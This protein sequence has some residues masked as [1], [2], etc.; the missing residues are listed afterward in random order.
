MKTRFSAE[1]ET[2]TSTLCADYHMY[3]RKISN[4][5]SF[6]KELICIALK[7]YSSKTNLT[8]LGIELSNE[9]FQV[10][11]ALSQDDMM[12]LFPGSLNS[13]KLPTSCHIKDDKDAVFKPKDLKMK[14][15]NDMT[16]SN[17]DATFVVCCLSKLDQLPITVNLKF[18]TSR[19]KQWKSTNSYK[20]SSKH[21]PLA[22][23]DTHLTAWHRDSMFT[24]KV[25][26]ISP[27]SM[28]VWVF[29]KVSGEMNIPDTWSL[30]EQMNHILIHQ[31]NLD[32]F[33]QKPGFLVKHRGSHAHFVLTYIKKDS[34]YGL[35]SVLVGWE[36][37]TPNTILACMKEDGPLVQV[38]GGYLKRVPVQEY[39][40]TVTSGQTLTMKAIA[41]TQIEITKFS[42]GRKLNSE[43]RARKKKSKAVRFKN[44][45]SFK[46]LTSQTIPLSC[47]TS[48]IS[49]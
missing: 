32:F 42:I 10:L 4:G 28:K 24:D 12:N 31:D 3:G 7:N 21:A 5:D 20:S 46:P 19:T 44:L 26:T 49:T 37:A 9:S 1:L 40:K 17:I 41:D 30:D 47:P 45:K 18:F 34:I 23:Y 38:S 35:W 29:E 15:Y 16:S 48:F 8:K 43:G 25:H 39:L 2:I 11:D 27:G 6:A 36:T 33:I 13:I 22:T 14:S